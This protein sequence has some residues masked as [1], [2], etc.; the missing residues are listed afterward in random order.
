[1]Y[2]PNC[3]WKGGPDAFVRVYFLVSSAVGN[4]DVT[5]TLNLMTNLNVGKT[6]SQLVRLV[7]GLNEFYIDVD[8]SDGNNLRMNDI[9]QGA[10]VISTNAKVVH[11][12]RAIAIF[13]CT[14]DVPFVDPRLWESADDSHLLKVAEEAN[15]YDLYPRFIGGDLTNSAALEATT[16]GA[17]Y[18]GNFRNFH[19]NNYEDSVNSKDSYY[20]LNLCSK[21]TT[22]TAG[23]QKALI[24]HKAKGSSITRTWNTS[25]HDKDY[26]SVGGLVGPSYNAATFST[27]SADL[28]IAGTTGTWTLYGAAL[29]LHPGSLDVDNASVAVLGDYQA[30]EW[31]TFD[32]IN[33]LS[34]CQFAQV[35]HQAGNVGCF[36]PHLGVSLTLTTTAATVTYIP[37]HAVGFWKPAVGFDQFPVL[38][39]IHIYT[40]TARTLTVYI[41]NLTDGSTYSFAVAIAIGDN[42]VSSLLAMTFDSAFYCNL[43]R[44]R[45][46]TNATQVVKLY[47]VTLQPIYAAAAF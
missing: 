29:Y 5:F 6:Y 2:G 46:K 20:T 34:E 13:T 47:N 24:R 41:D 32:Q 3:Y 4:E 7:V 21:G 9:Y 37:L 17:T 10:F 35:M 44:V 18:G 25:V 28:Y 1:L 14:P 33:T 23:T 11:N 40:A 27:V 16:T 45:M 38:V 19:L 36:M 42:N 8:F 26:R 12:Y 31:I 39:S 30:G 43:I 15:S 22:A